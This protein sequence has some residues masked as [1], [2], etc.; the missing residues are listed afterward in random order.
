MISATMPAFHAHDDDFLFQI[1]HPVELR[2]SDTATAFKERI[3]TRIR[4]GSTRHMMCQAP[5]VSASWQAEFLRVF[6][7]Y[8]WPF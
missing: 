7:L 4:N 2:S 5:T 6:K 8:Y 3:I 1:E